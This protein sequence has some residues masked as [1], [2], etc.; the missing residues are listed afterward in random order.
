[1]SEHKGTVIIVG[2]G[3]LTTPM[4]EEAHKEGLYTICFDIDLACAGMQ[5]ADEGCAVSTKDARACVQAALKARETALAANRPLRGVVTCGA[6]VE[7]TVASVAEACQ[8]PGIQPEVAQRIHN[9]ELMH[10]YLDSLGLGRKKAALLSRGGN[11]QVSSLP[12]PVVVKP[13]SNCAS[14][15][16]QI[17]RNEQEMLEA[18]NHAQRFSARNEPILVEEYL[19]GSKHTCEVIFEEEECYLVSIIDTHYISQ[20]YPCELGLN[21]TALEDSV[22]LALHETTRDLGRAL[23]INWGPFKA[24]VN[25]DGEKF[26]LIECTARLSG[27]FHCQY[28]TRAAFGTNEIRA[29]LLLSL[30]E[31][32]EPKLVRGTRRQNAAVRA[33]FPAPGKIRR[34]GVQSSD[35]NTSP[36]L[37][38]VDRIV[39][40]KKEGDLL[41][42][43]RNS[44]DRGFFSLARGK[45]LAEAITHA[46]QGARHIEHNVETEPFDRC[47]HCDSRDVVNIR[48]NIEEP[49]EFWCQNCSERFCYFEARSVELFDRA[50]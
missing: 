5:I 9:K 46:E 28:A 3:L 13:L 17:V 14:R 6:D 27:G 19:E 32:I 15:G 24:D 22:Q 31:R 20:R 2:G 45:T 50:G 29:V 44:S 41:G 11:S 7:Y 25:W 16:V 34:I 21:T 40:T 12:W 42:P 4:Y 18:F 33:A 30:G 26:R 10:D 35:T 47:P 23:G 1:M 37:E 39:M 8:L 49:L 43:Y 38:K 48:E 36:Y